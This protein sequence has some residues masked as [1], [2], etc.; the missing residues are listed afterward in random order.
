MGY[1]LEVGLDLAHCAGS[2]RVVAAEHRPRQSVTPDTS[3]SRVGEE[4]PEVGGRMDR[5]SISEWMYCVMT[6]ALRPRS[7][8]AM[9]AWPH[10]SLHSSGWNCKAPAAG[11]RNGGG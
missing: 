10:P 2:D 6:A 8:H 1:A 7:R 9:N 3:F 11:C 4:R 5:I